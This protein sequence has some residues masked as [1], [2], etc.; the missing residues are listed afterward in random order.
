MLSGKDNR[1]PPVDLQSQHIWVPEAGWGTPG[2][3]NVKQAP[4]NAR[5]DGRTDDTQALQRAI[6]QH[7]VVLLPTCANCKHC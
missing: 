1:E 6:D 7:D 3:V 5:G 2:A 4:Y